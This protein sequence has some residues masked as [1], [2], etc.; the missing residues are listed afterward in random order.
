[1]LLMMIKNVL[2]VNNFFKLIER[3]EGQ[4]QFNQTTSPIS[5]DDGAGVWGGPVAPLQ[6]LYRPLAEE[7]HQ[8]SQTTLGTLRRASFQTQT[9]P[10]PQAQTQARPQAPTQTRP[11]APTQTR[12]QAPTQ[13]RSPVETVKMGGVNNKVGV[14]NIS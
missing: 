13:T 11:Q 6:S 2:D 3:A 1:M 4:N 8:S 12:P 5:Q 7:V 9:Q 14:C 10:R